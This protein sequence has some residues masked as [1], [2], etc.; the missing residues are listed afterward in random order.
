M[1]REEMLVAVT[2][3]VRDVL[4]DE[5]IVLSEST[6]APDVPGWDSFAHIN[7]VVASEKEFGVRFRTHEIEQ[8]Q[9]VGEFVDLVTSK[10]AEG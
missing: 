1:T 6:S 8:L 3:I 4:D 7:I 10:R 5:S 2:E 9:N